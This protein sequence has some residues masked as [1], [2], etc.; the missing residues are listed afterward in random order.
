MKE[1]IR[2]GNV[3]WIR[4]CVNT[5]PDLKLTKTLLPKLAL[6]WDSIT[7][8]ISIRALNA[9][10]TFPTGNS[11]SMVKALSP[12]PMKK[13]LSKNTSSTRKS[14]TSVRYGSTQRKSSPK[15][16]M[17]GVTNRRTTK[18]TEMH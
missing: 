5:R 1:R 15:T 13:K 7:K 11:T 9:S 16:H 8:T 18:T 6:T 3:R 4:S 12:S 14:A 2:T 10:N 17:I